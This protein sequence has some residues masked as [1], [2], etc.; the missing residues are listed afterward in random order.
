[1]KY[2]GWW[3]L[4]IVL[5]PVVAAI[6]MLVVWEIVDGVL[7][8]V[9]FVLLGSAKLLLKTTGIWWTL[10]GKPITAWL[11]DEATRC[12]EARLAVCKWFSPNRR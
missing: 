2:L 11:V 3:L 7:A 1:M 10:M 12:I 9:T 4:A 5:S 8:A 6:V